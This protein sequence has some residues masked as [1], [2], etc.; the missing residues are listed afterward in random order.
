MHVDNIR[1]TILYLLIYES[2]VTK[3]VRATLIFF[4]KINNILVAAA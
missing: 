3:H 1:I 4:S 2:C